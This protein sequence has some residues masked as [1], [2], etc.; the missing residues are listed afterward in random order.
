MCFEYFNKA[1]VLEKPLAYFYLNIILEML[2][3]PPAELKF[4]KNSDGK[5][6]HFKRVVNS[7]VQEIGTL[8]SEKFNLTQADL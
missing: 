2:Q 5:L 4:M 7:T 1:L 6:G 3:I 8:F